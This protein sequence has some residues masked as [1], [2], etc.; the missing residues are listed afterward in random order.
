MNLFLP[1]KGK[2]TGR[3]ASLGN[4]LGRVS[5]F[6][7]EFS[8]KYHRKQCKTSSEARNSLENLSPL[9]IATLIKVLFLTQ[10]EWSM[11]RIIN[12]PLPKQGGLGW[13]SCLVGLFRWHPC[14]TRDTLSERV[15]A[16]CLSA[17]W[18]P[19]TLNSEISRV[20]ACE[21]EP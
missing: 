3:R 12:T 11:Q 7:R 15:P 1:L 16:L 2:A 18:H 14:G 10:S 21:Y 17:M 4:G 5:E 9:V 13:V 20:R 6:S 8:A 19:C